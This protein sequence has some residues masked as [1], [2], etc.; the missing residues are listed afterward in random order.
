MCPQVDVSQAGTGRGV[1]TIPYVWEDPPAITMRKESSK[2]DEE[3]GSQS[4]ASQGL[5]T[6]GIRELWKGA[7]P[8]YGWARRMKG[9][10]VG[11]LELRAGV[12]M[13]AR[14]SRVNAGAQ[15]LQWQAH[16]GGSQ[17]SPCTCPVQ[18]GKNVK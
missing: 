9:C 17:L 6:R 13:A 7:G 16:T 3:A 4:W 12:L 2:G 8:E 5:S 18:L 10:E 1:T 15:L 14:P 11:S